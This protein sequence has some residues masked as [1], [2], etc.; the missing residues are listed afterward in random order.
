MPLRPWNRKKPRHQ[1]DTTVT[2][3]SVFAAL[4]RLNAGPESIRDRHFRFFEYNRGFRWIGEDAQPARRVRVSGVR[5]G[6][7][8]KQS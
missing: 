8:P 2:H 4:H 1:R 5:F 6:V 7:S 3:N